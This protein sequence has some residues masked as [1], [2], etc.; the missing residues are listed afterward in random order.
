MKTNR[1]VT[2]LL[3]A[4]LASP[5]FAMAQTADVAKVQ[6]FFQSVIGILVSLAGLLSVAFFVWGGVGYITST[7][8]PDALDRS[9]RT[10]LYAALGLVI[11]LGAFVLS[12]IVTD[13]AKEAFGG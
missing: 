8:Q 13:L 10:V 4:A 1:L 6:T 7:G 3:L 2:L 12:N 5:P 9:K 11:C